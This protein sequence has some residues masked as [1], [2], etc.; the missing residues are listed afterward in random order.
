MREVNS[1]MIH[2]HDGG[3]QHEHAAG[4]A[5]HWHDA[6]G[7]HLARRHPSTV[8]IEVGDPVRAFDQTA[9]LAPAGPTY[10]YDVDPDPVHAPG[11][12][13]GVVPFESGD[14]LQT[15]SEY[16]VGSAWD[17]TERR[18]AMIAGRRAT[19]RLAVLRDTDKGRTN[20]TVDP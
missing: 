1:T 9:P 10:S 15:W 18:L 12:Y 14:P 16:A 6:K 11:T 20:W 17:G 7:A 13:H 8:R 2:S 5:P 3:E 19:D 4:H